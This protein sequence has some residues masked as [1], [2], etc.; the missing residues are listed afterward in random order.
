MTFSS[1]RRMTS[2]APSA[3]LIASILCERALAATSSAARA[4]ACHS[5]SN[6]EGWKDEREVR[7]DERER[8]GT[9]GKGVT[10]R[11]E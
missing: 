7:Q 3:S 5:C 8:G 6:M 10:E 1:A 4:L 9:K 11:E 2:L